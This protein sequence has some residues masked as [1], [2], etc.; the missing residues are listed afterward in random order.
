MP[1]RWTTSQACGPQS[2]H[3]QTCRHCLNGGVGELLAA[4]DNIALCGEC[5]A[6]RVV[7]SAA[8]EAFDRRG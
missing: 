2:K 7:K 3:V 1:G 6:C 4:M 8:G 5:C